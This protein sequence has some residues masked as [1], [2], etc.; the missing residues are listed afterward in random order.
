MSLASWI[1]E[2][3]CHSLW[4]PTKKRVMCL[5]TTCRYTDNVTSYYL[6]P[7]SKSLLR[8]CKA[9]LVSLA[10]QDTALLSVHMGTNLRLYVTTSVTRTQIHTK[11]PCTKNPHRKTD[12]YLCVSVCECVPEVCACLIN[13]ISHLLF[14]FHTAWIH[15]AAQSCTSLNFKSSPLSFAGR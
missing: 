3:T 11:P 15:P 5:G 13:K 6:L 9:K 1:P 12:T 7:A 10:E 8:M 14:L 4:Q 2:V